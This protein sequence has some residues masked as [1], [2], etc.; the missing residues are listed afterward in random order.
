MFDIVKP[1]LGHRAIY[2]YGPAEDAPLMRG[3]RWYTPHRIGSSQAPDQLGKTYA[4]GWPWDDAVMR[5]VYWVPGPPVAAALL[6]GTQAAL[7][8]AGVEEIASG[9]WNCRAD[10]IRRAMA[11][12]AR[13]RRVALWSVS[14]RD[15]EI[16]AAVKRAH[17]M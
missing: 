13:D 5:E 7:T 16:W 8:A 4:S 10:V 2:V 1:T 3:N 11:A 14:E 15:R 12:V 6:A 9:W 17:G